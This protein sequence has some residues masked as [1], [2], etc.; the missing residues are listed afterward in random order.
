MLEEVIAVSTG[1]SLQGEGLSR[2]LFLFGLALMVWMLCAYTAWHYGAGGRAV[3]VFETA[4]KYL[5]AMIILAFLWV[6]VRA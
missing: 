5:S 6:V 3:T 1:F 4:I 2:E